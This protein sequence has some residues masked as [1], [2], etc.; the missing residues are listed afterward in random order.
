M[1]FRSLQFKIS[2]FIGIVLIISCF[3]LTFNSIASSLHYYGPMTD[4]VIRIND[5]IKDDIE[6][7]KVLPNTKSNYKSSVTSDEIQVTIP[8]GYA[9]SPILIPKYFSLQNIIT[10]IIIIILSILLTYFI[11]GKILKPLKK[12]SEDITQINEHNLDWRINIP[13][14]TDEVRHLANSFNDMLQRLEGAFVIKKQFAAN[15]AHELKTPLTIIKTTL[16]VLNLDDNP[17]IDDYKESFNY[18]EKSL[19]KLIDTVNN[20]ISLTN[21]SIKDNFE[22]IKLK[23]ILQQILFELLD[24]IKEKNINISLSEKEFVIKGHKT[25]I[26]RAFYNLIENSIKYNKVNGAIDIHL[27][28]KAPNRVNIIIS[29]SGFGISENDLKHIYEPFFRANHTI[30]ESIDGSGLGMSIVKLIIEKHNG[31]INI[32]SKK[33][34]GTTISILL[35]LN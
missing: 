3:I 5:N 17:S 22:K 21:E 27:E 31:E 19:E 35:N 32:E 12:L 23:E 24:K 14:S 7:T 18:I 16:Q 11:T 15:A 25:L 6:I 10:M 28:N 1:K 20:L 13:K 34:S 9:Y 33:D 30:S 26:F 2:F 4:F 29:D 8:K